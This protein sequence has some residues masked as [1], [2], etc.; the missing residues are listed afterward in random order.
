M[1]KD[2]IQKLADYVHTAEKEK[3]E[4][5]R[6]TYELYPELTIEEAYLVQEELIRQKLKEGK[7]IVGPKMGITSEAKMKQMNVDDPIYGYI[8]DDM[9]V[10]DRDSISIANYIHPKV[11]PEIGFILSRDLEGPNITLSNVLALRC[12]M[13]MQIIRRLPGLYLARI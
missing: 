4:I 3:R 6:I 13:S 8:F 5:T 7:Q 10:D 2:F 11:E 9:V 1:D 12:Q